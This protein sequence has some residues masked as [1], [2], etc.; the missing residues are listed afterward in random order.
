MLQHAP[1]CIHRCNSATPPPIL[2][3]TCCGR[4]DHHSFSIAVC[5][6]L[7]GLVV[8]NVGDY[9][10]VVRMANGQEQTMKAFLKD[11]FDYEHDMIGYV[12]LIMFAFVALFWCLG[13]YAFQKLNFQKR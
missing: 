10:N 7:Y 13:A 5:C 2:V 9:D 8:S 12:V 3:H 4:S 6:S 1:S 11:T